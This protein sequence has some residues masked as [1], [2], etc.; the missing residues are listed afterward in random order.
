MKKIVMISAS[1]SATSRLNGM[2]EAAE[3]A[4][5]RGG[6]A[7]ER[8][9]IRDIAPDVLIGLKFDHPEI[10]SAMQQIEQADAVIVA[11]PVYKAA[12]SGLLK[13]FLDLIPQKGLQ[14]KRILPIVIGGTL[15]HLLMIDYALKPVLS[16][17]GA[18]D[19]LQGVFGLDTQVERL[20]GSEYKLDEDLSRRLQQQISALLEPR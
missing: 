15:A 19:Q 5:S 17:L 16:A 6:A 13:I 11:T 4:L 7:L 20:A 10:T 8:I 3:Q 12:Y 1:P 18:E 14:H 9:E 2:L